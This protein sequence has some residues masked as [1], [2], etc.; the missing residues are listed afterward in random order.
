M[1]PPPEDKR[2]DGAAPDPHFDSVGQAE[3]VLDATIRTAL[4]VGAALADTQATLQRS[5][6]NRGPSFGAP[7]PSSSYTPPTYVHVVSAEEGKRAREQAMKDVEGR[8]CVAK[9]LSYLDLLDLNGEELTLEAGVKQ[10]IE[11]T[12]ARV[13]RVENLSP[14]EKKYG[15]E[16]HNLVS[17]QG[18]YELANLESKLRNKLLDILEAIG[19]EPSPY[20]LSVSWA[21]WDI[22]KQ[23]YLNKNREQSDGTKYHL[24]DPFVDRQVQADIVHR[25]LG[26]ELHQNWRGQARATIASHI[27]S[28]SEKAR[29]L[30]L[31]D[32]PGKA[33]NQTLASNELLE[34]GR[35]AA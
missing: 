26:W 21:F 2:L 13:G 23:S 28:K 20:S 19:V 27:N 8:L 3:R 17:T 15:S 9:Y 30:E 18:E 14:A 1:R 16:F 29:I 24:G 25:H 11:A 6:I 12:R 35:L 32:K 5:V 7:L 22:A 33:E 4:D 10:K 34:L 31:L